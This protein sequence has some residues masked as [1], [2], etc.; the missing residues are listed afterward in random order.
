MDDNKV[1]G[2]IPGAVTGIASSSCLLTKENPFVFGD[3]LNDL[4]KLLV[5]FPTVHPIGLF[6]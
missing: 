3:P 5:F 6:L 4:R 1:T 2:K